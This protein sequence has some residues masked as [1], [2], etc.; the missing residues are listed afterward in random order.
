MFY[1]N[2][3][4]E[5]KWNDNFLAFSLYK[6]ERHIGG[7]LLLFKLPIIMKKQLNNLSMVMVYI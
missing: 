3:V 7:E 2:K 6:N 4:C 5:M 1:E